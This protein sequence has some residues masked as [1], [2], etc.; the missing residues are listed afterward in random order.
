[1]RWIIP[2][3]IISQ[4]HSRYTVEQDSRHG[5]WDSV[6]WKVLGEKKEALSKELGR[7]REASPT[8]W[9][10]LG[11]T[12]A[13]PL[14]ITLWATGCRPLIYTVHPASMTSTCLTKH[15]PQYTNEKKFWLYSNKIRKGLRKSIQGLKQIYPQSHCGQNSHLPCELYGLLSGFSL[16]VSCN[17]IWPTVNW[18]PCS[19]KLLQWSSNE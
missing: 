14:K 7:Q 5:Q 3:T 12:L 15:E 19:E 13:M 4:L 9:L 17:T 1:M 6:Q 2:Y 18:K 16:Y 10:C 8:S 11:L